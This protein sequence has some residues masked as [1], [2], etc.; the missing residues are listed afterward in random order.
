MVAGARTRSAII[1]PIDVRW[2][3]R[4]FPDFLDRHPPTDSE[5]QSRDANDFLDR[6][7]GTGDI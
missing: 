1:S 4:H 5:R 2:L 6:L 3:G 7:M